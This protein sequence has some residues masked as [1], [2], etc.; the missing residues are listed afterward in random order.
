[1]DFN[2]IITAWLTQYGF[3][4][5]G[6]IVI[7]FFGRIIVQRLTQLVTAILNRQNVEP[8]LVSFLENLTYLLTMAMVIIA[9]LNL[10]G[11]QTASI[12]AILGAAT[13]ALGFALQDSLSNFAAG[14]M[15]VFFKPYQ[16]G[17]LVE[18]NGETG[19]VQAVQ[20]FNTNLNAV[21][22]KRIIISN[23]S[24]LG[25]NMINYS[26]NGRVR[27][28]MVFGIGYGD[29]LLK[30]KGILLDILTAQPEVLTDPAPT[31]SVLEL[32]DSS[33]NFAV[34][35]Y[36]TVQDY[37]TVHFTTHEQVKLRFDAEGISIPYPTQD[38][39]LIKPA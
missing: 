14:V 38:I 29:D 19:V 18:I 30:A 24:A 37:W 33:V 36:V 17:D 12:V 21:D 20:I 31:V 9:A 16:V 7:L 35:P 28:D 5:L 2:N 8:T 25:A 22:N 32:G 3:N 27:L 23:S 26:T 10:I 39:N 34:R 13:L 1:M 15:I 11:F 4:I 6:A